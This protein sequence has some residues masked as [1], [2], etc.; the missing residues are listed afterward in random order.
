M[1]SAYNCTEY[2]YRFLKESKELFQ[3]GS[4]VLEFTR[5]RTLSGSE[6]NIVE[7]T[8]LEEEMKRLSREVLR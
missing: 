2:K 1:E 3:A 6:L 8:F 7:D 5:K 4:K